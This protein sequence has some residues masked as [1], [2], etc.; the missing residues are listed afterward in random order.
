MTER[1][2]DAVNAI[3]NHYVRHST[4]T[5][6]LEPETAEARAAWFHDHGAAHPLLVAEQDGGVVG[7]A[8]LS[9]YHSRCGYASTVENSVY[10]RHDAHRRG[11]GSALLA[12]LVAR[13]RALGHHVI[14]AG[15]DASQAGSI[16]L[17]TRFNFVHAGCL[18]EVGHKFGRWLDVVYMQ[19]VI[20]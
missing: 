18:R 13:A 11:I 20:R 19:L 3:Y 5:Y 14:V 1:D 6:Q 10:V 4:C 9:R 8:S 2:L 7:W 16:A 12:E 15:I 17:H